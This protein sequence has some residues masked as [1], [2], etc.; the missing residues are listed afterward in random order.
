MAVQYTLWV[1]E[2]RLL[3]EILAEHIDQHGLYALL[4]IPGVRE[5]LV[6]WFS[7]EIRQ[8]YEMSQQTC[9]LPG[10]ERRSP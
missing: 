9:A 7:D 6:R 1:D 5:P 2:D 4:D 8:R 3:M 10:A